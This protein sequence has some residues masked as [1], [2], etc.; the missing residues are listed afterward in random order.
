MI[1]KIKTASKIKTTAKM[2]MNPETSPK[3][4]HKARPENSN[5][6]KKVDDNKN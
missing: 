6:L 4:K 1:S 3:Y 2:K 5:N